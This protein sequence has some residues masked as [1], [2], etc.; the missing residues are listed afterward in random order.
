[1]RKRQ[2]PV[3]LKDMTGE[4]LARPEGLILV[5]L[6]TGI[7]KGIALWKA[8]GKRQLVWFVLVLFFNTLG[9]LEILYIFWLN[10]W[11]LDKEEKLLRFL[12]T[13]IGRKIKTS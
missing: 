7:W 13:K 5:V 4:F 8:A 6:W 1:M 9:L 11:P 10:R 3:K 2:R 12:Q